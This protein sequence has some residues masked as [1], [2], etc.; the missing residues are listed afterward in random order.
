MGIYYVI[1][2]VTN[3]Y[4]WVSSILIVATIFNNNI[5]LLIYD[6]YSVITHYSIYVIPVCHV[7]VN[8]YISHRDGINYTKCDMT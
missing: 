8:I 7:Y 4:L 2:Y 3:G 6:F 5:A 1:Y